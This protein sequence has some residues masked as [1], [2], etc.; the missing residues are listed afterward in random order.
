MTAGLTSFPQACV[1]A[2]GLGTRLRSIAGEEPKV[3]VKIGGRPIL[4]WVLRW[5]E[6]QGCREVVLCLGHRAEAV[7]EFVRG[8]SSKLKF[9]FSVESEPLGTA[10]ALKWALPLLEEQTL[11]VNGDTFFETDLV[12]LIQFHNKVGAVVTMAL[13][14]VRHTARFGHVELGAQGLVQRFDEK[15]ARAEDGLINAGVYLVQAKLL[16][17][18]IPSGT[19]SLER[20]VF[21]ALVQKGHLLYGLVLQGRFF[22]IGTPEG[23]AKA[24]QAFAENPPRLAGG[25][26][27]TP[28]FPIS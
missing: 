19:G 2:G 5:L 10:G 3:L 26:L 6:G 11:V 18:F 1:L 8:L 7:Q 24:Q 13:T 4:E 28:S 9:F 23:Y 22:D 14:R 17:T 15:P 21:P 25:R 12:P 16:Q 27:W 20:Q